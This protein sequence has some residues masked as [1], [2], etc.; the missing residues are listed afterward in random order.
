MTILLHR[1]RSNQGFTLIEM[2]IAI[3]ITAVVMASVF[4]LLKRGQDRFIREPEVADMTAN[5]RAGLDLISRDLTWAGFRSPPTMS[6][7]WSDGGG[8]NP[9]NP[10]ELTIVF[11][12]PNVPT[13]RPVCPGGGGGGNGGG[14]NG[15][16]GGTVKNGSALF[17]DP[18][19][20]IPPVADPTKA[21]RDGQVLVALEIE[22]CNGDG[23]GM[24]PFSLTKPPQMSGTRLHLM[25]NPKGA[26]NGPKGF[27]GEV[28]ADCAVIGVFNVIQY[29]INPL[30]PAD[31]PALE[32]RNVGLG[33]AWSPVAANIENLQVRYSQGIVEL[34][35]DVPSVASDWNDP[36]SWITGVRV[37]VSG[38]SEST[39]LAGGTAGVFAVGD[40]HLRKAFTTSV[41]LRN[42]LAHAQDW[43]VENDVAGWN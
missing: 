33:E 25:R 8:I 28:S 10:D 34:F 16:G 29:R 18:D 38:R 2:L 3:A 37:T 26:F 42:Q 30:P 13:S 27:N 12:D 31:N 6:I 15:G 20:M 22:D 9:E 43:A 32:R 40:T 21:Y 17:V 14:G 11:A 23:L 36:N 19:S 7:M 41:I 35:E 4:Q 5:A 24:V 39:N 1:S